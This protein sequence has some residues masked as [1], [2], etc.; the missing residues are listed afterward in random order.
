[1]KLKYSINN[2][3]NRAAYKLKDLDHISKELYHKRP[4]IRFRFMAEAFL[5][6]YLTQINPSELAELQDYLKATNNLPSRKYF[7]PAERRKQ[8]LEVKND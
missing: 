8:V 6:Y 1:M 7:L 5:E 3:M 4:D 2:L